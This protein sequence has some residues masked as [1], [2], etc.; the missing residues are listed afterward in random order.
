MTTILLLLAFVLTPFLALAEDGGDVPGY[1]R[2]NAS[3]IYLCHDKSTAVACAT[4]DLQGPYKAISINLD[5]FT[6]C[7]VLDI[8]IEHKA[9]SAGTFSTLADIN[10]ATA[11][12]VLVMGPVGRYIRGN[13]ITAT[14]CAAG[15]V[16]LTMEIIR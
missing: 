15:G 8:D 7:T 12:A 11:T 5:S 16:D 6:S 4:I 2:P 13:I 1:S 9:T 14:S 3:A 10:M